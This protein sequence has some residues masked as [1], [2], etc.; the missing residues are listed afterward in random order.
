MVHLD[1]C[2][3]AAS[4]P[5]FGA[6]GDEG[7]ETKSRSPSADDGDA[8]VAAAEGVATLS[9]ASLAAFF[10]RHNPGKV[11]KVN[12]LLRKYTGDR[13]EELLAKLYRKYG[14]RPKLR[15]PGEEE[16]RPADVEAER[17]EAAS[18]A[19]GRCIAINIGAGCVARRVEF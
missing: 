17:A 16:A 19:L 4:Q 7:A 13:Q 12:A 5:P 14:T 10:E 2:A 6:N 3:A 9:R 18:H 1:A 15:L 11:A 8:N